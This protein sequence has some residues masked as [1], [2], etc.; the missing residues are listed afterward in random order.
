MKQIILCFLF[1]S[2]TPPVLTIFTFPSFDPFF[3]YFFLYLNHIFIFISYFIL[4][5][6][7]DLNMC[8]E[9]LVEL[10]YYFG[11]SPARIFLECNFCLSHSF[12][13]SDLLYLPLPL[14]SLPFG[15]FLN[16]LF[17]PSFFLFFISSFLSFILSSSSFFL[18]FFL[19]SILTAQLCHFCPTPKYF[20]G[21]Q[22]C[23]LASYGPYQ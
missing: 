15:T 21:T 17:F 13:Y 10:I 12:Y 6:V 19:S 5:F 16:I 8:D 4:Y 22:L 18:T 9:F 23:L 14:N 20:S 3:F 7:F 2:D 11:N 1:Y